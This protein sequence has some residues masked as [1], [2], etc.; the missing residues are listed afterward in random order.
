MLVEVRTADGPLEI[1]GNFMQRLPSSHYLAAWVDEEP[2]GQVC[3]YLSQG[4]WWTEHLFVREDLRSL[5][6]SRV[7]R[8]C[9]YHHALDHAQRLYGRVKKG[10]KVTA[11][12]YA[13]YDRTLN[14][15]RA[16]L[17]GD[18][19][20]YLQVYRDIRPLA[21]QVRRG[22]VQRITFPHHRGLPDR[23]LCR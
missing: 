6:I 7:L 13:A 15:P 9:S 23:E 14:L 1:D 12:T 22:E 19:P 20:T 17:V 3:H 4:Q 10:P 8:E 2:V 5:G 21:E 16:V 11:E 18:Y